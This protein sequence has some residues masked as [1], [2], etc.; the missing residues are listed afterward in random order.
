MKSTT[1]RTLA[2]VITGVAAAVGAAA[3]PAAA[4]GTVPVTV[5]LNGAEKAL[6]TELPEVG[7]E[8]PL[9][10]ADRP[11]APRF[12]TGRLLP[13]RTVPQVPVNGGLPG[14]GARAPLAHVL[15]DGFDHVGV[16]APATPL[17]TLTPGLSLDAPLTAPNPA[18]SHLPDLKQPEIGILAPVLRTD[19]AAALTAGT[20]R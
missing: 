19:P 14:L 7:G 10:A 8:I 20:G 16:A 4:A 15:G 12:V 3:T 9:P 5:P 2:A 11:E 18:G 6:G 1:R 17:R 13:E